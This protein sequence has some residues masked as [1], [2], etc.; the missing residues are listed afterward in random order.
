[1]ERGLCYPYGEHRTIEEQL[2]LDHTRAELFFTHLNFRECVDGWLSVE[3][4]SSKA[5]REY[6][7]AIMGACLPGGGRGIFLRL[8]IRLFLGAIRRPLI[9]FAIFNPHRRPKLKPSLR[10]IEFL[11]LSSDSALKL[12]M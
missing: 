4:T 12:L 2:L 6:R 9:F 10:S 5:H 7:R 8:T 11:G 3:S 1:M